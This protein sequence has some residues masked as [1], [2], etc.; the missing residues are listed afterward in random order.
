MLG[1]IPTGFKATRK[2]CL[3][4]LDAEPVEST[5][6]VAPEPDQSHLLKLCE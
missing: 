3:V 5:T 1:D 2:A 6:P 4:V